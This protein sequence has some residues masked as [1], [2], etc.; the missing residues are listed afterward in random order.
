MSRYRRPYMPTS[1]WI[2]QRADFDWDEW[3]ADRYFRFAPE[4]LFDRLDLLTNKANLA[5]TLGSVEW[6]VASLSLKADTAMVDRFIEAAWAAQ[7]HPRYLNYT[8]FDVDA[9]RGPARGPLYVCML[10]L[11]DAVHELRTDPR[12]GARACWAYNLARHVIPDAQPFLTWW[13]LAV[14]RLE[15]CHT[16]AQELDGAPPADIFDD[17]PHQGMPVPAPALDPATPYD[18]DQA[19]VWW[20]FYLQGL[21]PTRNEF[22]ATAEQLEKA[23]FLP[24]S[25]Y[26]N[27]V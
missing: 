4:S 11:N 23:D 18:P 26:R 14:S 17:F 15:Q 12:V 10:I 9:W 1:L 19:P 3:Q 22:L 20:D 27:L 24:A 6:V 16:E 8:E 5:L 13:E 7:V 21:D 2:D 25:P